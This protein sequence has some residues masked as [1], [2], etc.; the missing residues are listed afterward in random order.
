MNR[1]LTIRMTAAAAAFVLALA[2]LA[3]AE[4]DTL[5]MKKKD[6]IGSYPTDG[7]GMTLYTF[8]SDKKDKNSRAGPCL[9][10]WPLSYGGKITAPSISDE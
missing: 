2:G 5:Q 9:E 10:K 6:D 1:R 8:K 4:G 7:K 3:M